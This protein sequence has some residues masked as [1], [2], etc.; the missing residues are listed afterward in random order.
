MDQVSPV[1]ALRQAVDKVGTLTKFGQVIGVSQSAVSQMLKKGSVLGAEH[2]LK[3]EAATG[4][5][6]HVLRPDLYPTDPAAKP[7]SLGDL[8]PAR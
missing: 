5:S 3:V 6:R 7:A 1:Q 4:I 8:E 2:V